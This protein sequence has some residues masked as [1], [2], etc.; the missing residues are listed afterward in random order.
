MP[1]DTPATPDVPTDTPATPDVPTDTPAT[2]D[3]PAPDVGPEL[4]PGD[5]PHDAGPDVVIDPFDRL[6]PGI[7]PECRPPDLG[8]PGDDWCAGETK[9]IAGACQ[10]A[11]AAPDYAFG[12]V[13][14]VTALRLP[15]GD[16]GSGFDYTGDGLPDNAL[17]D[18]VALYPGGTELVN[19]TVARYIDRGLYTVLAEFRGVPADACGPLQLAILPATGDLDRDGL[20]DGSGQYQVRPTGFRADGYGPAAQLNL[21]AI[22]G[23]LVV[24][25]AGTAFNALL[26]LPDGTVFEV[27]IEGLRLRA[28][29]DLAAKSGHHAKD[30][31][32][33]E[34]GGYI[35]LASLVAAFNADAAGCTCA[36]VDADVPPAELVADEAGLQARCVASFDDSACTEAGDGKVCANLSATC[37]ALLVMSTRLDVTSGATTD[38]TGAPIPDA[39][40][41]AL[42]ATLAPATLAEPP[43]APDFDAVPDTWRVLPELDLADDTEPVQIGVLLNDFYDAAVSPVIVDVTQGSAGGA[44]A[45]GPDGTTVRYT[46]TPGYYGFDDFTYT[47]RDGAGNTSTAPVEV[48]ITTLGTPDCQAD[49]SA[50]CDRYCRHDAVCDPDGFGAAWPTHDACVRACLSDRA[51]AWRLDTVCGRASR[52]MEACRIILHCGAMPEFAAAVATLQAGGAVTADM[53]CGGRIAD[54]VAACGACAPGSYGP[55]CSPCPGGAETP[56]AGVAECHDG[57]SGDGVCDCGPGFAFTGAACQDVDECAETP[58]LCG[59]TGFCVNYDGRYGCSCEPGLVFDGSVGACVAP[60]APCQPNPCLQEPYASSGECTPDPDSAVGYRCDCAAPY[61]WDGRYGACRL[62]GAGCEPNLC[63]RDPHASGTCFDYGDGSFICDCTA[64]GP[65]FWDWDAK[66]C[67]DPCAQLDCSSDAHST[68]ECYVPSAIGEAEC[69]C[70]EGYSWHYWFAWCWDPAAP[71]ELDPCGRIPHALPG[72]CV[73]SDWYNVTCDCDEGYMWNEGVQACD[74]P[75]GA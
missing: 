30:G 14:V 33:A 50:Y 71:C 43:L 9:C 19:A 1:A 3:V 26:P 11:V 10:P 29:L 68:G 63:L 57:A 8:C 45:V 48:R 53:P 59:A 31:P 52:C 66:R 35:R 70:L 74:P 65:Y 4:P 38:P 58:P 34:F 24:S 36:G 15:P 27:P 62:P 32:N 69:M 21:A 56:C 18:A 23:S 25:G 67:V 20:P 46:P 39:L 28:E 49:A 72:T 55:D 2:P 47:I 7:R 42:Y 12:A 44:V 64:G 41:I 40:S 60:L 73:P 13:R 61:D 37:L 22:D 17:A 16:G 51:P 6:Y 5:A 75:S 54:Q